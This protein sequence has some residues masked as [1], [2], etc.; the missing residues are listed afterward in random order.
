MNG[1][2]TD[3][4]RTAYKISELAHNRAGVAAFMK[5]YREGGHDAAL[6]LKAAADHA[7]W[8]ANM[9]RKRVDKYRAEGQAWLVDLTI[10]SVTTA[11]QIAEELDASCQRLLARRPVKEAPA[12]Q[13]PARYDCPCGLHIIDWS[14]DVAGFRDDIADHEATCDG[15]PVRVA[16]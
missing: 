10:I 3:T 8:I 14:D 2:M 6:E 1:G 16:S 11:D 7:R 12:H 15:L 5:G 4:D 9:N 13:E